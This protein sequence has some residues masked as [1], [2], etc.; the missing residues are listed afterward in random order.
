MG[1]CVQ[2]GEDI[3]Y[4]ETELEEARWFE[5]G[6]IEHALEKGANAMWELPI[7]N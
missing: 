3:T 4:P 7:K 2:G 5:L 1:Q 6:E